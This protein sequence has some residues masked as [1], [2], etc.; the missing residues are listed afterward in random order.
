M[1]GAQARK[2]QWPRSVNRG[3]IDHLPLALGEQ[4]VRPLDQLFVLNP[5]D[6]DRRKISR[7]PQ[8]GLGF[9][10]RLRRKNGGQGRTH[11]HSK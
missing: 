4:M 5:H 2:K 9:F 1:P 8:I 3:A 6:P 7:R 11:G 10:D